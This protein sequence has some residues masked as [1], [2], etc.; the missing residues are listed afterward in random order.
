MT[1]YTSVERT[2]Y[3]MSVMFWRHYNDVIMT[4]MTSQITSLTIV[5]STVYLGADQR[6]HQSS[7]SLGLVLGIQRWPV[8]SPRKVPVPRKMFPFYDVIMEKWRVIM[9]RCN[10]KQ[11]FIVCSMLQTMVDFNPSTCRQIFNIRR[12]PVGNKI[13]ITQM[14]LSALLQLHLY[15]RL[16]TWLQCIG[17]RQAQDGMRII[18]VLGFEASYIRDFTVYVITSM[19]K[20]LIQSQTSTVQLF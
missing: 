8:N 1:P 13:L 6:K 9:W 7:A 12:A 19:T 18:E 16:I 14:C 5:Y 11:D 2:G 10:I 3:G 15:S 20:L 17:R 4:T